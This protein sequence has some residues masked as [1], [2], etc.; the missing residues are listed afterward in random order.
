MY[1]LTL[2][3]TSR[4]IVTV[5]YQSGEALFCAIAEANEKDSPAYDEGSGLDRLLLEATG[6]LPPALP[7]A[8]WP[9]E[10]ARTIESVLLQWHREDSGPGTVLYT[11]V[12]LLKDQVHVC[13][14]GDCRV[15]LVKDGQL[16]AVTRDHNLIDDPV[17]GQ[18]IDTDET[19]RT[20]YLGA[21]T[22]TVGV[23][24]SARPPERQSWQAGGNYTVLICS[25]RF[26]NYRPP[27]AYLNH[28]MKNAGPEPS[29]RGPRP[30]G[31]MFKID[32]IAV[33]DEM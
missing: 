32:S 8:D 2:I 29:E 15:H 24:P 18:T 31:I 14:A 4:H 13:T 33:S 16:V 23:A 25:S 11:G 28:L 12:A 10:M 17:E 19:L 7:P 5:T 9:S 26:H 21:V 3:N 22:R 6:L 27:N 30:P 20:V 1:K